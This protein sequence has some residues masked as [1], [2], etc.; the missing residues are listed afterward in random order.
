MELIGISHPPTVATVQG[1]EELERWRRRQLRHIA[2]WWGA[3]ALSMLLGFGCSAVGA[4]PLALILMLPAVAALF[5]APALTTVF[6]LRY[7]QAGRTAESLPRMPRAKLL[8]RRAPAALP[9]AS[10]EEKLPAA[11]ER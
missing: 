10:A 3:P 11:E 9:A 7:R 8:Q 1:S 2:W 4:W 6:L 5:L